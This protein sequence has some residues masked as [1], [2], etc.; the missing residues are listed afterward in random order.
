MESSVLDVPNKSRENSTSA[1]TAAVEAAAVGVAALEREIERMKIES[2]FRQIAYD[3]LAAKHQTL[4]LRS[5]NMCSQSTV[6]DCIDQV[7]QGTN[8]DVDY[9]REMSK[10]TTKISSFQFLQEVDRNLMESM[11]R[12]H[13]TQQSDFLAAKA[14][15]ETRLQDVTLDLQTAEAGRST[16]LQQVHDLSTALA[17]SQSSKAALQNGLEQL[18]GECRQATHSYAAYLRQQEVNAVEFNMTERLLKEERNDLERNYHEMKQQHQSAITNIRDMEHLTLRLQGDLTRV[19]VELEAQQKAMSLAQSDSSALQAKCVAM[20]AAYDAVSAKLAATQNELT[21][22]SQLMTQMHQTHNADSDMVAT[23]TRQ[24]RELQDAKDLMQAVHERHTQACDD[25]TRALQAKCVAMATAN[26]AVSETLT[27]TQGELT[28]QLQVVAQMKVQHTAD[29]D[30]VVASQRLLKDTKDR[31]DAAQARQVQAWDVERGCLKERVAI[32]ED[33]I[34]GLRLTNDAWQVKYQAMH[35]RVGDMTSQLEALQLQCADALSTSDDTNAK[36]A[37]DMDHLARTNVDLHDALVALTAQHEA[38][39]NHYDLAVERIE[40][41]EVAGAQTTVKLNLA[42]CHREM[43]VQTLIKLDDQWTQA[44]ALASQN[45][46]TEG[47]AAVAAKEKQCAELR[48]QIVSMDAMLHSSTEL[49]DALA[50]KCDDLEAQC[51]VADAFKDSCHELLARCDSQDAWFDAVDRVQLPP[52]PTLNEPVLSPTMETQ[53]TDDIFHGSHEVVAEIAPMEMIEKQDDGR[54]VAV[55]VGA[56]RVQAGLVSAQEDGWSLP[57]LQWEVC[58]KD[59]TCI[60]TKYM[61]VIVTTTAQMALKAAGMSTGLVVE[62]C[63]DG[64][65]VIPIYDD[66]IVHGTVPAALLASLDRCD[67]MYMDT[68]CGSVVLTGA[69]AK[70]PGLKRRLVKEVVLARPELL[71][72]L[73]VDVPDASDMQPYWGACTYAKYAADDEWTQQERSHATT[74]L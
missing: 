60:E 31:M 55:V 73:F 48:D 30:L 25:V 7:A 18:E 68:F 57:M 56:Y 28:R 29:S 61:L 22:Q 53:P 32:L 70:L 19:T 27:A 21:A 44:L 13:T 39:C 63:V 2:R 38:N 71:G 26:D 42:A 11:R 41:L 51:R 33:S 8:T 74:I 3:Q 45:A 35:C 12:D 36:C 9:E 1:S 5:A 72:Q 16:T 43:L 23:L 65:F 64:T 58:L 54:I 50:R 66:A 59:I 4:V 47:A 52:T 10:L 34:E 17:S 6:T 46:Q 20:S 40:A 15:L 14:S 49:N 67:P 24:L 69:M 62:F 37:R